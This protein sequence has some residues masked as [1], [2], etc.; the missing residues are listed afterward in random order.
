[1]A[2]GLIKILCKIVFGKGD[3]NGRT[4]SR[5]TSVKSRCVLVAAMDQGVVGFSYPDST[6]QPEFNQQRVP[7]VFNGGKQEGT[8]RIKWART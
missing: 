3:E 6:N 4:F 1:M 5:S 2:N 7:V 8:G